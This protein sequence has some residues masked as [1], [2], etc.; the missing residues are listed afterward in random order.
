MLEIINRCNDPFFNLALEEYLLNREDIKKDIFLLWQNRPV[1]V[2]GRNQNTIEEIN[3]SFIQEKG[4]EVVRRIS[5]GGAVYHDLGNLNFTFIV[6]DSPSLTLDFTRFTAPVIKALQTIGVKAEDQGRNDISIRGRKF[7]GNAQCRQKGRLMHHGTILF[8]TNLEDMEQALTVD[9][10]K[11]SSKGVKSVMSR[12]T[13]IAEHISSSVT[14]EEFQDIL[15]NTIDR[16]REC[17]ELSTFEL[18]V[19]ESLRDN[20]FRRWE[21]VY[22]FSPSFNIRKSQRFDWGS[23]DF[24]INVKKGL[25]IDCKIYGDFFAT[26]DI[27]IIEQQLIGVRYRNEDMLQALESMNLASYFPE[28]YLNDIIELIRK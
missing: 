11:I 4:I 27:G 28:A 16:D 5:G 23:I 26:G 21:W 6:N 25:I 15:S 24:R 9:Y 22:G 7:S 13:N 1:V 18:S 3:Q 8:D 20:K 10:A 2:V 17:R 12:V 19:V 14:I